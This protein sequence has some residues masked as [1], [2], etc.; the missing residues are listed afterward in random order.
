MT[1]H[2]AAGRRVIRV[3][4]F[5]PYPCGRVWSALT[6]GNLVARWL[7]VNDF[8][9]ERGRRIPVGT[10]PV[11]RV[12]LGGTGQ[13]E[14][15]AFEEATMLR[16]SW[17]A[18]RSEQRGLDSAVTFTLAPEGAGTRLLVEHDGQHPCGM[19]VGAAR[20]TTRGCFISAR[21]VGEVEETAG[22]WRAAVGRIGDLLSAAT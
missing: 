3:E 17:Q 6:T 14:V 2:Q 18:A 13:F 8:R 19:A 16:I 15:L 4:E 7:M 11:R 21:R 12:G 5:L 22:A 20:L 9:L 10:D 1:G